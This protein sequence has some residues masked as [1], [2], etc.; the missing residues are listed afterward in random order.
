MKPSSFIFLLAGIFQ[1]SY[2][3]SARADVLD[4]WTTTQV[5]T[6]S[7]GLQNVVYGN[8]CYVAV[9]EYSDFGAIYSSADGFNWTLRYSDPGAWGLKMAFCGGRFAGVSSWGITVVSTNG[10]NWTA[11]ALPYQYAGSFGMPF[12]AGYGLGVYVVVGQTNGVGT[13][14]TSTDAITWTSRRSAPRQAGPV[15]SLTYG[16]STLVAVGNNDGFEYTSS[17]GVHWTQSSIPGGNQ[18]SFG[19]GLFFVPLNNQT[20][21]ISLD[22][23][24]WSQQATGLTNRLG[25]IVYVNGIYL[26]GGTSLATS[27]DGTNWFQYPQ[28]I[29]GT[30][31]IATDGT[32]L[33]TVSG[34]YS[35]LYWHN[36]FSYVSDVLVGVQMTNSPSPRIALSG[37][38][39]RNYQIQSADILTTGSNNWRTNATLQLTNTPYIWTDAAATNSQR[40]YRGVLLP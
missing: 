20:N 33:V 27:S 18:I 4:N 19:N 17:D 31:N 34:F 32:R 5:N 29:P 39:G 10:T 25:K 11:G 30:S 7:Y 24:T 36:S 23:F 37:L 14:L 2:L 21:L 1:I 3:T 6:N 28:T 15:V 35:G 9:G 40:F 13:I 26:S 22:G 38:V 8:G 12:D 16:A